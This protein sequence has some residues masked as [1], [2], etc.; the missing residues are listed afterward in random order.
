MQAHEAARSLEMSY[1]QKR[2][3][4]AFAQHEDWHQT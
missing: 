3:A 4:A 2:A 1:Y